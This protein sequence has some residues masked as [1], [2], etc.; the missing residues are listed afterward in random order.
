MKYKT[1][2]YK[3]TF[4]PCVRM[5]FYSL[6]RALLNENK[7]KCMFDDRSNLLKTF[8]FFERKEEDDNKSYLCF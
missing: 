4:K 8:T 5:Y 7:T 6:F 1:I 2:K 3:Q